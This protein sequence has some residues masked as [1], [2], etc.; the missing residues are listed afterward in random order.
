MPLAVAAAAAEPTKQAPALHPATWS[1][2]GSPAQEKES[3]WRGEADAL[4]ESR[5]G[6]FQDI[7][8]GHGKRILRRNRVLHRNQ[9]A[10]HGL[11]NRHKHL[12][13]PVIPCLSH[14]E[15]TAVHPE[16]NRK[17]LS[18][19]L[20]LLRDEDQGDTVHALFR[21]LKCAG[22]LV[23]AAVDEPI[24]LT[25]NGRV[26][27]SANSAEKGARHDALDQL[28]KEGQVIATPEKD[29]APQ[30]PHSKQGKRPTEDP[31]AKGRGFP[32]ETEADESANC[33][34]ESFD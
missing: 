20:I 1:L 15:A 2:L 19:L 32:A 31:A 18:R 33:F 23:K 9:D 14:R 28:V 29:S 30:G 34:F 21:H 16:E 5:G 24:D 6:T 17:L 12:G 3:Q 27:L 11:P 13:S 22:D 4:L 26:G 10:I 7:I 8:E 25:S